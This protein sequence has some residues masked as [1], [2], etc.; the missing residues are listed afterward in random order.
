MRLGLVRSTAGFAICASAA[1]GFALAAQTDPMIGDWKLNVAK[2]KY[3]P[4]PPPRSSALNVHQFGE[5]LMAMFDNVTAKGKAVQ[6]TFTV[7][8]DGRPHPVTGNAVID[9]GSC[10][11]SS[12]YSQEFTNMKDGRVTTTGT[13][14]VSPDGRTMTISAKGTNANG[15]VDNVAVYER[16]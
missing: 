11:R 13:I 2:S 4:G 8:C 9:A 10:R 7:I 6:S 12:P 14:V 1:L 16:Q 15:P 5:G 3:S